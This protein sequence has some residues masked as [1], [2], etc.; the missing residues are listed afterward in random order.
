VV[1]FKTLT[2]H[3]V[4]SVAT[5]FRFGGVFSKS[6]TKN[7]LLIQTV[8]ISSKIGQYLIKC[9]SFFGGANL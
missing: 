2:F 1:A 3:K 8:K 7:V 9:A 4:V 5:H 6:I